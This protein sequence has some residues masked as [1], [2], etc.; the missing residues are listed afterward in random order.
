MVLVKLMID[1]TARYPR[2][3]A[4]EVYPVVRETENSLRVRRPE[5]RADGK[6][7]AYAEE[8]IS[9]NKLRHVQTGKGG[10]FAKVCYWLSE[11]ERL[12]E[13]KKSIQMETAVLR[14]V[15]TIRAELQNVAASLAAIE[16]ER[17]CD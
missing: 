7:F 2:T 8:C 9:K 15:D 17:R 16:G 1:P 13:I 3:I 6:R 5:F 11:E 14:I 10:P 12:S 4:L